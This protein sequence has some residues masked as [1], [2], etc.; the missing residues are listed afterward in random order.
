MKITLTT[1][2][3]N[4]PVFQFI[5]DERRFVTGAVCIPAIPE[6]Q[7][8]HWTIELPDGLKEA[9]NGKNLD[10]LR[11]DTGTNLNNWRII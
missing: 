8:I 10:N 3:K 5:V 7:T 4:Q 9:I 11:N 6:S 2:C 1:R